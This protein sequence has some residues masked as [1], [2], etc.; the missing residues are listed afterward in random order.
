MKYLQCT[1][2]FIKNWLLDIFLNFFVEKIN[3]QI[4]I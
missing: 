4:A 1:R 3:I 2:I